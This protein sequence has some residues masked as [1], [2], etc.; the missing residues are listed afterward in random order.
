MKESDRLSG[1]RAAN[2]ARLTARLHRMALLARFANDAR[3]V[4]TELIT[5]KTGPGRKSKEIARDFVKQYPLPA[6]SGRGDGYAGAL[7]M[8]IELEKAGRVRR[9]I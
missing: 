9:R 5:P 3:S 1:L 4:G 8:L 2:A 6:S 7:R